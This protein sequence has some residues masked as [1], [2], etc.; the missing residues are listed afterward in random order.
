MSWSNRYIGIPSEAFGRGH[1]G[2]DCW[3]L[4]CIIYRE[5]LGIT[6]PDYLGAYTS[7]DE[8]GEIAALI[9]GGAT[10]PL[11]V[12]VEGPAIAFDIAVFRRGR[13]SGH[14]G[15]VVKHGLMI[16][17]VAEDGSKVQT[18]RDGPYKHRFL[19]HY[20]HASRAIERPVQILS[21]VRP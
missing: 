14:I 2:C 8:M 18:Y 17:A 20:R 9:D 7:A 6:L 11:W 13:W 19:G 5:E 10:S 3:G 21:E 1:T 16:H 4:A 15:V 12:P